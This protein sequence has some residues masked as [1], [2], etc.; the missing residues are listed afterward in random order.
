MPKVLDEQGYIFYFY[1]A[2]C[3]ERCHV[4]VKK[5]EGEGKVWLLPQIEVFYLRN[6]KSKK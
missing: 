2:D 3:K 1:A 5:G 6:L 4:H